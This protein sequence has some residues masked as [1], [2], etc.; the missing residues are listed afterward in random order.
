[1]KYTDEVLNAEAYC[2]P[3]VKQW[4]GDITNNKCW[5]DIIP[6]P[7]YEPNSLDSANKIYKFLQVRHV[8][9][10]VDYGAKKPAYIDFKGTYGIGDYE[11]YFKLTMDFYYR[12]KSEAETIHHKSYPFLSNAFPNNTQYI[13]Y[14]SKILMVLIPKEKLN[15]VMTSEKYKSIFDPSNMKWKQDK[16][17]KTG[18]LLRKNIVFDLNCKSDMDLLVEAGALFYGLKGDKYVRLTP[19]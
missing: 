5:F 3:F 15:K 19:I 12:D 8:D 4:V 7:N 11:G 13:L 9:L 10:I 17:D 1:M 6:V 18:R 2:L 14:A 16:A